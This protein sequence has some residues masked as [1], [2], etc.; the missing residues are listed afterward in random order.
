[1]VSRIKFVESR[2]LCWDLLGPLSSSLDRSLGYADVA[3]N[4]PVIKKSPLGLS[5][6]CAVGGIS[7]LHRFF[8]LK[9]ALVDID[10]TSSASLTAEVLHMALLILR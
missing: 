6:A 9:L 2:D 3:F 7:S 10:V 1:M 5:Q 8:T 4:F